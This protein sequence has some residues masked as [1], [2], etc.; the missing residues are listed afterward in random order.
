[1]FATMHTTM[2]L[3]GFIAWY[4][5]SQLYGFKTWFPSDRNGIMKWCDSSRLRLIIQSL[6]TIKNKKLTEIQ[7]YIYSPR[8]I[9]QNSYKPSYIKLKH[10][11]TVRFQDPVPI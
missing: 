1:M 5:F 3:Y 11:W 4:I 8:D 2:Q 6:I 9:F 10:A 7:V